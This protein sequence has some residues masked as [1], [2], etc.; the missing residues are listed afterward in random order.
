MFYNNGTDDVETGRLVQIDYFSTFE[1]LRKFVI[2]YVK[3][4]EFHIKFPVNKTR[5]P[6][7]RIWLAE[8]RNI[9]N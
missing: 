2:S 6:L 5:L 8:C 9:I 3:Q 4:A 1:L 7:R